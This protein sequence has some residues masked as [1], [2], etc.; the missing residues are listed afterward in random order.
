[1]GDV[2]EIYEKK[3]AGCSIRGIA[4]ELGIARNAVRRYLRIPEA[5][6]PGPRPLRGSNPAASS[7][8]PVCGI[9]R[10]AD[11]RGVEN[12]RVLQRELR[13]LGDEGSYTILAEYVRPRMRGRQP[14][15]TVRFDTAP[16]ER[17]EPV[18][19][20]GDFL[21]PGP[22]PPETASCGPALNPWEAGRRRRWEV[23]IC[24]LFVAVSHHAIRAEMFPGDVDGTGPPLLCRLEMPAP[25]AAR[26]CPTRIDTGGVGSALPQ[27]QYRLDQVREAQRRKKS[28]GG[29]PVTVLSGVLTGPE[30]GRRTPQLESLG[31]RLRSTAACLP[32]TFARPL[33]STRN[34]EM[35]MGISM[36][37]GQ[38]GQD[39]GQ[40][41]KGAAG[42]RVFDALQNLDPGGH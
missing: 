27:M 15:A 23:Q 7:G 40:D 18:R 8:G 28:K 33:N 26:T 6:R 37:P 21:S 17:V 9:H 39:R 24:T 32:E 36:V 16:G 34:K 5:M 3:G 10:Q 11:G 1:M 14:K 29:N 2:K 41:P 20:G 30:A 12:C 42:D 31:L 13:A 25:T 22:T 4:D 35:H 38:L 19:D